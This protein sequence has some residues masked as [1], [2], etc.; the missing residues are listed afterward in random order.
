MNSKIVISG[1]GILCSVAN[2]VSEFLSA[3]KQGRSGIATPAHGQFHPANVHAAATIQHFNFEEQLSAIPD[4]PASMYQHAERLGRRAPLPIQS[5]IICALQSWCAARL[6]QTKFS[7]E[8]VGIILACNYAFDDYLYKASQKFSLNPE[9]LSPRFAL[10]ALDTD[11]IGVISELLN[12]QGEGCVVGAASAS[13]NVALIKASQ[14]IRSGELD[15]CLVIGAL[16]D[17]SPLALQAFHNMGAAGKA[18]R[19]FDVGHDGFIY[20]QGCGAVMLESECFMANRQAEPLAEFLS[21]TTCLAGTSLP[22]PSCA[23]EARAMLGS[24]K[25]A[26]LAIK[27]V[28]YINAHGTSTPMGDITE[29]E[30]IKQVFSEDIHRI[31]INSTKGMLGHCLFSAGIIEAIACIV[32]LR[33]SFVHP[34]LNL[35]H[36]IREGFLFAPDTFVTANL[37]IAMSNSFGFSGFNSSLLL[38]KVG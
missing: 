36:K 22:A 33:N 37:K 30:A 15:A 32:Q 31:W 35:S 16:S 24:L 34:N 14:L 29:L 2:N 25:K 3:L 5:S 10:H 26:G 28:D 38:K 13:G 18:C 17:L 11:H 12:L 1:M 20:G 6:F 21:G 8:R 9:Y 23:A 27:D 19:P 4:V 7:A